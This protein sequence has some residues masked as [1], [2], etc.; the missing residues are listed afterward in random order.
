M[1]H[2]SS[3]RSVTFCLKYATICAVIG[4]SLVSAYHSLT[5]VRDKQACHAWYKRTG[6]ETWWVGG[7]CYRIDAGKLVEAPIYHRT[8][9]APRQ[10]NL[11]GMRSLRRPLGHCTPSHYD[12]AG[13]WWPGICDVSDID[14]E[15]EYSL[16]ALTGRNYG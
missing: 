6:N 14:L 16:A 11:S 10:I 7:T 2:P 13:K 5:A 12:E 1:R 9:S 3:R 4:F 15:P 8:A